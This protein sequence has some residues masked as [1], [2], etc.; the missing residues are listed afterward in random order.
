MGH[1]IK[2]VPKKKETILRQLVRFLESTWRYRE[3]SAW[4]YRNGNQ[5]LSLITFT[6]QLEKVGEIS[7]L[8]PST[9]PFSEE[10]KKS[11]SESG[12]IVAVKVMRCHNQDIFPTA[13]KWWPSRRR[14][15]A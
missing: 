12:I 3:V 4:H 1:L 14:S 7:L 15:R 8:C 2:T 11:A 5:K 6:Y 13:H 9:V 10:T